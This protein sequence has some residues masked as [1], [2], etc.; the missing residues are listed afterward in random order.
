MKSTRLLSL[1]GS[2]GGG[3]TRLA[4]EYAAGTLRRFQDGAWMLELAPLGDGSLVVPAIGDVFEIREQ[5]GVPLLD[6]V[7]AHLV[8][9]QA[10]PRLGQLRTSRR[11]LRRRRSADPGFL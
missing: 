6:S 8:D 3:T 4:I 11:R 5:P 9:R 10:L 2:G 7:I 1:V